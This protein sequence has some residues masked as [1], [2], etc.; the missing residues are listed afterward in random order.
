MMDWTSGL[1]PSRVT[2][3]VQGSRKGAVALV[4]LGAVGAVGMVVACGG[5]CVDYFQSLNVLNGLLLLRG[6]VPPLK[7]TVAFKLLL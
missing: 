7:G 3:A 6:Q 5:V 1:E 2:K 4:E